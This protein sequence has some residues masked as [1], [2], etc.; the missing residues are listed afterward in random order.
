MTSQPPANVDAGNGFGLA[1]S[2]E[3]RFGNVETTLSGSVTL[4][5]ASNPGGATLGGNLTVAAPEGEATFSGLTINTAGTDYTLQAT[6]SGLTPTTTTPF[7]EITAPV[8]H[9]AVF[10]QPAAVIAGGYFQLTVVAEDAQGATDTSFTGSVTLALASNPGGATL[11]GTL[12]LPVSD[13][14]LTFYGLTL[15]QPGSGYTIQATSSGFTPATTSP[16]TV[17]TPPATQLI[18]TAP[19]PS[20]VT[21]NGDFGLTVAVVD[22]SGNLAPGYNGSVTVA[23]VGQRGKGKLYG[24][25]TATAIKGVATFSGLTLTKAGK[26]DTLRLTGTGLTPTTTSPFNVNAAA[27]PLKATRHPHP[28]KAKH[29]KARG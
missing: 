26:G 21:A 20:S 25:L 19:P 22:A 28:S 12:T 18:V 17:A 5:L 14:M 3:D 4:A 9:L 24:T 29:T 2:V 16:I 23:L 13:G 11:G 10:D 15:N 8:P 7:T 27:R 1:V 6:G